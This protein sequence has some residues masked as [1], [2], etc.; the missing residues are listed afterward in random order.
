M[1]RLFET[2]RII[3][4]IPQNLLLHQERMN[5]SRKILFGETRLIRLA[6]YLNIPEDPELKIE[7]CKVVYGSSINSVEF[8]SY[9][10]ANIRTLRI[11]ESDS[12]V[13]DHK[14]S[15][16]SGLLCL[17]DK[18]S[19]DDILIVKNKF[20][21]DTSFSNIIFSDGKQWYTPD[22]P[23]LRGT[24]RQFLIQEGII[25]EAIITIEDI[26]RFI[27]FRLINAMLGFDS[28][29]LPLSNLISGHSHSE[30]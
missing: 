6:D 1:C 23:L 13:Y 21:T 15:D 4:S 29:I 7:R 17:V 22:T 11:V 12:L 8:S 18:Q 25:K 19:A 2:I 20:V 30:T 5:R 14:Y 9:T 28:P 26:K 3:N 16:R 10:P 24:M 27:H